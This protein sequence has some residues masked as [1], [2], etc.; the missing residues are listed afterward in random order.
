MNQEFLDAFLQNFQM[1]I[2]ILVTFL[3]EAFRQILA[4]FLF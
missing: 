2:D 1:A 3:Q 4:A